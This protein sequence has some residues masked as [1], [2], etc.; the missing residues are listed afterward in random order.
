[1]IWTNGLTGE[2]S[3]ATVHSEAEPTYNYPISILIFFLTSRNPIL[4]G[5]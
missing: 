1:M 5:A 3:R 4:F 2:T